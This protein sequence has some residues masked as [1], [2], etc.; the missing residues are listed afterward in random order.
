MWRLRRLSRGRLVTADK[1]VYACT[2][3][4]RALDQLYRL[5]MLGGSFGS[6][7]FR[8]ACSAEAHLDS[9]KPA[10]IIRAEEKKTTRRN[11]IGIRKRASRLKSRAPQPMSQKTSFH[12]LRFP[13]TRSA[14]TPFS[15]SFCRC[16]HR[17]N[18]FRIAPPQTTGESYPPAEPAC[19]ILRRSIRPT[20]PPLPV[21]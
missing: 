18:Q 20:S 3:I 14:S 15:R 12:F 13:S 9:K 8:K 19:R 5:K 10:M 21:S 11:Q 2:K 1:S 17:S 16:T 6:G 4:P 7:R